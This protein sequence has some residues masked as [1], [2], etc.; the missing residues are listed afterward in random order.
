MAVPLC[1]AFGFVNSLGAAGVKVISSYAAC[2]DTA[3]VEKFEEFERRDDDQ[4][5]KKLYLETTTSGRCIFLRA[6][7]LLEAGETKGR[8]ICIQ[9]DAQCYWT[10]ASAVATQ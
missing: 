9:H 1:L 8:W 10:A 3:A 6:G 5:Y 2:K 4:G 7:E